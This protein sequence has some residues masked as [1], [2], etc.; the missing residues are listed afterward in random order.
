MASGGLIEVIWPE[1][2][3]G[4]LIL[5]LYLII[6]VAL[7][8]RARSKITQQSAK[9]WILLVCLCC[10][11]VLLGPLYFYLQAPYLQVY[12]PQFTVEAQAY[13]IALISA[14][15]YLLAG[16]LL[17]GGPAAI[18]GFATGL[19]FAFGETRQIYTPFHFAFAAWIAA[20]LLRQVYRGRVYLVLRQPLTAGLISQLSLA[21]MAAFAS[22][23]NAFGIIQSL[24]AAAATFQS[25]L[26]RAV[27]V[28]LVSG[29]FVALIKKLLAPWF[30][31]PRLVP[32]PAQR[33]MRAYIQTNFLVFGIMTLVASTLFVFFLT[34]II[35]TR[36]RVTQLAANGAIGLMETEEFQSALY[37]K[38]AQAG[39]QEVYIR[40]D[41]PTAARALGRLYKSADGF[42]QLIL[43]SDGPNLVYQFPPQRANGQLSDR[44]QSAANRALED[45]LMSTV[46]SDI[47]GL[48]RSLSYVIPIRSN[49][50]NQPRALIGRVLASTLISMLGDLEGAAAAG[51]IIDRND[52]ILASTSGQ[53]V[54]ANSFD[55]EG[56]RHLFVPAYLGGSA[57]LAGNLDKGKDLVYVSPPN[58]AGWR[59]VAHAPYEGI[60][61]Q[62]F[63]STLPIV[64]V[65]VA[66]GGFYY[67]RFDAYANQLVKPISDLSK[68]SRML[69][70]GEKATVNVNSDRQD[71]LG[72]L[73][74]SVNAMQRTLRTR[75]EE[76]DLL[77]HVTQQ[78]SASDNI[79]QSMPVLL[80]GA[81]RGTGASG[82]R[83]VILNPSGRVPLSFSEGPEGDKLSVLDRTLMRS[84]TSE[85]ELMIGSAAEMQE[86]LG[87]DE[88]EVPVKS[89]VAFSLQLQSAFSGIFCVGYRDWR[90]QTLRDKRFLQTLAGQAALMIENT[91]LLAT[92]EGG[93]QRLRAV[94]SSTSEA[95]LVTD[96]TNR[97]L[98]IN[99]AMRQAFGI[100]S[101]QAVGS[102]VSEIVPS[103]QLAKALHQSKDGLS[104]VEIVGKDDRCYLANISPIAGRRQNVLGRVVVMHD[105]T[106]LREADR[107]KSEFVT[108]VTHDLKTPMTIISGF[109]S[110]LTFTDNLSD[111]QKQIADNII[112]E[113]DRMANL[114]D[115]LLDLGRLESGVTLSME[116][117]YAKDLLTELVDDHWLHAHHSGVRLRVRV[118][119]ELPP[120]TGD[121][122]WLY[123]A[124][125]NLL[126]NGLKYAPDSGEMVLSAVRVDDNAV[127]SVHD[128][129]PGIARK[130]QKDLFERFYRAKNKKN[131]KIKGAGLG[132][133]IVKSVTDRHGGQAWCQSEQG[134]GSTFS[135]S[136]PIEGANKD[137]IA[138]AI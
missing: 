127:F 52:N 55:L 18:V 14:V 85:D 57:F 51:Q 134:K 19:G 39:Q 82:A 30:P 38:L 100:S 64:L 136:I 86:M 66:L 35:A 97:I 133:A 83:I 49:G 74:R 121:K 92:A 118:T 58:S 27:L 26:T 40:A 113:V 15:P 45:G 126:S 20:Q 44:E 119:P 116:E 114:V 132:L 43:L 61:N 99:R 70:V 68:A 25:V 78:V 110:A 2:V 137:S 81:I 32:T 80:R 41:K 95:V 7:L 130:D 89:L 3:A 115:N 72:E 135:I 21:S 98:L 29:A 122:A 62:A 60:L 129:G 54:P 50:A 53:S 91:H 56:S 24:D 106:E 16:L 87:M 103:P 1:S 75:S 128:N 79:Y 104:N 33:S 101:E 125:S 46:V 108:N 13:A 69:A 47:P 59:I 73:G 67:S 84:L 138:V 12:F 94:L 22:F 10:L 36:S 102:A 37:S 71:E 34:S 105:V 131:P 8:V 77:L 109:A 120:V 76:L 9:S 6:L 11:A 112:R 88:K 48:G 23:I 90:G 111:E 124:M 4:W 31:V 123:Q 107:M 93:R 63:A 65:L 28:G 117:F 17:G 96:H 42:D 5:L